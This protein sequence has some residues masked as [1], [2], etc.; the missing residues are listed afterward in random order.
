[1]ERETVVRQNRCDEEMNFLLYGCFFF[2]AAMQVL[3]A[4]A[5]HRSLANTVNMALYLVFVPGFVFRLGYC[6]GRLRRMNSGSYRKKW[7]RGTALRYYLY[8]LVLTMV[9]ELRPGLFTMSWPGGKYQVISVFSDV[10]AGLRL[11][12]VSAVFLTL[13]LMLLLVWAFDAAL[14]RLIARRKLM[15]TVGAL[16]LLCAF[17]RL[18]GE[19]YPVLASLFGSESQPAV[20]GVPYFAF[21]LLGVWFE[22]HKPGFQPKLALTMAA[23][24]AVSALLYRTPLQALCRVTISCLPVYAVYAAAE[25]C[26]ELTLRSR[27]LRNFC[28]MT[29]LFFGICTMTVFVLEGAGVCAG[30]SV[31]RILLT[32]AAVP[33]LLF[34]VSFVLML[35]ERVYTAAAVCLQERVRH[36]T[37]AYFVIY[38]AAFALMFALVFAVFIREGKTF[39]WR[40]DTVSQYY[41]R[42]V[43]FANYI[44]DLLSNFLKGDFTLPMYDFRMGLGSEVVYSMEPLYFLFALFGADKTEFTYNLLVVLRFYLAG[45]TLS[46]LCLYFKKDYFSTFIASA[47]YVF[48]GFSLF[49]GARHTMFMIPM[50]LLPLQIIAIEEILRRRRWYLCTILTALALFSNYY[51][52]YMSTFGMGVYFLVRYFCGSGKKSLRDFIGRGLV[53]CGTYLLG[54]AMACVILVSNFGLYVGSGRS[55]SAIIKTP[56][57]FF[58]SPEWLLRCFMSFPTTANSPG[59]WLKLGFLPIAFFAV[60]FLFARKGRRELKIFSVISLILMALPLSGFVLSGF[61][62]IS[63]RWCYMIALLAAYLVAECLPDMRCMSRREIIACAAVAGVYGYFAF[64][65]NYLDTNFTKLAF[66]CLCVTFAVLLLSQD[67]VK[68]L[69]QYGKQ[70]L[71]ILLTFAMVFHS[72]YTLFGIANVAG[73]YTSPGESARRSGNTPLTAVKETGD[74]D[75][76]RVASPRLD[77]LTISSSIMYDYNSIYM[78]NST[79]N[80]SITEYLEKMG[81][82]SYSATQLMGMNN[83]AF[84]EALAAV[85]YY[86]YYPDDT[87]AM[88]CGYEEVLRTNVNDSETVVCENQYALPIGYTYKEAMTREELEQYDVLERQEVMMQRVMLEDEKL[89]QEWESADEAGAEKTADASGTPETTAERLKIKSTKESGIRLLDTALIAGMEEIDTGSGE[90]EEQDDTYTLKLKFNSLPDS[91]TY[92]ILKNGV[93][94]GD[95]SETPIN[96]IFR[97]GDERYSFKFRSDDDRYGSQQQDYVFNLGY[98]K[99]KITSCTLRMDREGMIQFDSMELY[100][101]PMERLADYTAALTGDVLEDVELD[102]NKVSGHISLDEDKILTLSIPYQRGWTA[103][104]DGEPAELQRANYMYMALPLKAGEHTVELEFAI[105]GMKYALVIM[106]AAVILFIILCVISWIFRRKKSHKKTMGE[107]A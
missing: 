50:I 59:D 11:P 16:F 51:F 74:E 73:E 47:V 49:G 75:F 91:E 30:M 34:A 89:A 63:N 25:G 10:L 56:S 77:Y 66:F 96:L 7:L 62:A 101:Q 99:E 78:F 79:L 65:G 5:D 33:V 21:F 68:K 44:R 106:P 23:V 61:S 83:R 58:Y 14:D 48:C 19:A 18:R 41:P 55:G 93:L 22:Q 53:I 76:Y 46:V 8:F 6:Y 64:F 90:T 39:L 1:M 92:L 2:F 38:T 86:A 24:T 107:K 60:V 29:E 45:V 97:V 4:G 95:G 98:H 12:A 81:A 88:P 28:S 67:H 42:A 72:G 36:K 3:A 82:A 87:R 100:S 103:Y 20:P 104:V 105:P 26:S 70:G 13:A 15:L 40:A 69:T 32:A 9:C 57:L 85:K 84:M 102:T 17:L 27:F 43:F 94:K 35:L 37:A 31:P 52:L 71:M 54:A 80:G